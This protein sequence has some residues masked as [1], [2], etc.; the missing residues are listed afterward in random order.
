MKLVLFH[1]PEKG[2]VLPGLLTDRGV[3]SIA[4]AVTLSYSPQ[5]TMEGIIDDFENLR[6]ALERLSAEGEAMPLDEVRLS[7]AYNVIRIAVTM[8]MEP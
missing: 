8:M 6:P 7:P 1:T 2:D 4:G 3:V 5:M